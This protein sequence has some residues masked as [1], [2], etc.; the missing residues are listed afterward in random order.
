M[1][2]K[3]ILLGLDCATP[4]LLFAKYRDQLPTINQLR[5]VGD[6]G[7]LCSTIPP[8]T[9]PAW[10]AM[11]TGKDPGELGLYGFRNRQSGHYDLF[12]TN[13]SAVQAER[14]W[15]RLHRQQDIRSLII[16][17]PQ[18]FPPHIDNGILISGIMT[19]SME[20]DYVWPASYQE[21]LARVVP[22]YKC[23]VKNFR[24]LEKSCL[25]EEIKNMTTNRFQLLRH[26]IHSE[27]WQFAMMVE[28]GLDR[29]H[30]IFW[31]DDAALLDYYKLLDRE[32]AET[33]AGIDKTTNL[34]IVSDHGA[35]TMIGGF[36]I[37]DWLIARG[38][39]MLKHLPTTVQPFATANVDWERTIAWGAGGYYG[40][41]FLNVAG[42]EP[43]G[44]IP[45]E[46]L[47]RI[48]NEIADKLQNASPR[49]ANRVFF[50]EQ[51]YRKLTGMPPDLVVYFDDLNYRSIGSIGHKDILTSEN[52]EGYDL[53]NHAQEGVFIV[54]DGAA[55]S[56]LENGTL[57]ITSVFDMVMEYFRM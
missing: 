55:A 27:T 2:K 31:E 54:T 14:I 11:T 38:Y 37:N 15:D 53:A 30:H 10:T 3:L 20:L 16:G 22:D 23:D 39:L 45:P 49:L 4:E 48:R 28:I 21:T 56:L 46:N 13:N 35:K 34:W 50:P 43:Q 41:I 24:T 19:P 26:M 17:V 5:V 40:R 51:I 36:C 8:I 29:M 42:R 32:I 18:T 57:P 1:Q 52:D 33:M 44:I 7:R 9:V 6:S 47:N 25:L 12:P